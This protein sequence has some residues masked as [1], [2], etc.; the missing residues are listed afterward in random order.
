MGNASP[1]PGAKIL[2]LLKALAPTSRAAAF[3]RHSVR[4]SIEERGPG[5]RLTDEGREYARLFGHQVAWSGPIEIRHSPAERC[6]ESAH[7]V[8]RGI[9][10]AHPDSSVS[11]LGS[12]ESLSAMLHTDSYR[13]AV[14]DLLR[15]IQSSAGPDPP[16]KWDRSDELVDFAESVGMWIT[17]RIIQLLRSGGE[18]TLHLFLDHDLHLIVLREHMFGTHFRQWDWVGYLDGFV[19]EWTS[20]NR[21]LVTAGDKRADYSAPP[22]HGS[23]Y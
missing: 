17:Q 12:K 10:R 19:L 11:I 14:E 5:A 18:S 8:A 3:I 21:I 6:R 20:S 16:L 15:Q 23:A 9:R 13:P 22:K 4:E 2:R 1:P 7:L